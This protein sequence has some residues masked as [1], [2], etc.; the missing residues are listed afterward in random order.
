MYGGVLMLWNILGAAAFAGAVL[1]L[2]WALRGLMLTPVRAGA[3]TRISVLIEIRGADSSLESAV[4]ALEW[5]DANGTLP[6]RI[7]VRGEGMD[8]ATLDAALAL[9]RAGRI[10]LLNEG[11]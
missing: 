11:E 3:D 2:V 10:T 4:A 6:C 1:L 7:L 9:E 5:L 8:E